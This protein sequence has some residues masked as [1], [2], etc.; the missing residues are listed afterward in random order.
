MVM[1]SQRRELMQAATELIERAASC[2]VHRKYLDDDVVVHASLPKAYV[3]SCLEFQS[4]LDDLGYTLAFA[5]EDEGARVVIQQ[6]REFD[7][8]ASTYLRSREEYRIAMVFL[9]ET[10]QKLTLLLG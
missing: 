9:R 2:L 3:D 6:I 5:P 1:H 7:A 4:F 8:A 10:I